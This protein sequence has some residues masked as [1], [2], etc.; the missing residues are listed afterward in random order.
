MDQNINE[1]KKNEFSE[2][3]EKGWLELRSYQAHKWTRKQ[4]R[5]FKKFNREMHKRLIK[6]AKNFQPW[7][8]CFLI[9]LIEISL[10]Y[11]KG[12]Y[13]RGVYVYQH[14]ES[15]NEVLEEL[16][17]ALKYLKKYYEEDDKSWKDGKPDKAIE[18]F[19]SYIGKNI[20]K[21]WD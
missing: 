14:E 17:W 2:T 10:Q 12:I 15:Q 13:E 9:D 21:W 20:L 19:F 16:T 1:T 6:A 11:M 3:A 18:K 4:K 7:D 8:Y 5:E